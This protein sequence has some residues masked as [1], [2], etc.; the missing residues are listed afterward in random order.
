MP[1]SWVLPGG[2]IDPGESLENAVV[3]EL[4]EETGIKI[5]SD[6]NKLSFENSPVT[7]F[8]FYAFESSVS[9]AKILKETT[10]KGMRY[11]IDWMQC[12]F[13]HLIIFF[14]VQLAC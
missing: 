6:G 9:K 12:P 3:R 13:A 11:E 7:L 10:E 14:R 5:Q 2:H 4:E 1:N 8:P